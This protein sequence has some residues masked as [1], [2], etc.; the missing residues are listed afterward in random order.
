LAYDSYNALIGH[1]GF[2]GRCLALQY[3]F[4]ATFNSANI[5]DI[6][7]Q[8]FDTVVCAAA[9]G[10][11]L[12][13]NRAPEVDRAAI[14]ALTEQLSGVTAR[15]FV[16]IS[17]IA[18][19]ADFAGG[20]DEDT[21]AFQEILAYGRHRR[22]L[23][24]FCETQFESCLVVR[25]PALF[26]PGLRKNLIFDLLHPVP[27]MLPE[28]RLRAMLEQLT[29]DLRDAIAVLY[30]P[31]SVTGMH[32]LDRVALNADPRRGAVDASGRLLGL[33]ATRVHHPDNT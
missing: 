12:K 28:A 27:S 19:L 7:G 25:L 6:T 32:R 17:S 22:M 33:P 2:V 23:E 1:T 9:P 15:R 10:S 11:M 16:L 24:M 3:G 31:D 5:G 21:Q 8:A 18:V 30:S 26:G 4:E 13:A 14:Y 20:D 29:P